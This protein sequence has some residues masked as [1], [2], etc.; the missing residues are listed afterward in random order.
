MHS[1]VALLGRPDRPTDGVAD[2]AKFLGEALRAQD[3]DLTI[4]R[5]EWMDRGWLAALGELFRES[6]RWNGTWVFL[7]YTA[8]GWSRRGFPWG[9]IASAI[10]LRAC[11]VRVGIVFHEPAALP[12]SGFVGRFRSGFQNWTVRMLHRLSQRSVFTIPLNTVPWLSARDEKSSFIPLGPNIPENL[13]KRF[14]SVDGS[15]TVKS[16][17]IF[18]VSEFPYGEREVEDIAGATNLAATGLN[19]LRVLFVGRGTSEAK[20]AIDSAFSGGSVEPVHYGIRAA[21]EVGRIF[22]EADALLAVRGTFYLRRGSALAGLACGLPILG[23]A[24]A[25]REAILDEAGI[26]LVPYRDQKALGLALRE[27]LT[28]QLLWQ[29]LHEKN[30]AIQKRYFS[31]TVI[32]ESYASFMR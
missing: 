7:Q 6:K 14:A 4:A 19:K 18:C 1:V 9:A 20:A 17:V 10:V 23:Y 28:D 12:G 30:L 5:V 16:V 8:L 27:V 3:F 24:S 25:Q 2:Y 21:S 22:S 15:T 32:A 29:S 13:T 31:W 11:G 26:I